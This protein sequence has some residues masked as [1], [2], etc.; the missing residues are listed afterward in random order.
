MKNAIKA[1]DEQK[2]NNIFLFLKGIFFLLQPLPV[3]KTMCT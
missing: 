3:M 2:Q 1:L